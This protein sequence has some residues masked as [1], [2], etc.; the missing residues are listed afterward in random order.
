[1]LM[2]IITLF[3]G[4]VLFSITYFNKNSKIKKEE[5][6]FKDD[7]NCLSVIKKD[8]NESN[9]SK[10]ETCIDNISISERDN[11]FLLYF[12]ANHYR[13][14][15]KFKECDIVFSKIIKL[16]ERKIKD[17]SVRIFE[18]NVLEKSKNLR[19]TYQK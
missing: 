6:Q 17:K 19:T 9:Y 2:V 5:L 18:L 14:N 11:I 4:T 10:W 12:T 16:I 1:M 3:V 7:L 13:L 15:G 8:I